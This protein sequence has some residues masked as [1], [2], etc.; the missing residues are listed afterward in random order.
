MELYTGPKFEAK[1]G[2]DIKK[3]D[4]AKRRKKAQE[5]YSKGYDRGEIAEIL[6]I[7]R[8]TV[9]GYLRDK[10]IPVQKREN[11]NNSLCDYCGK[12]DNLTLYRHSYLCRECLCEDN[13]PVTVENNLNQMNALIDDIYEDRI[14]HKN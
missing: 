7:L 10:K 3:A 1:T 11:K 14:V 8:N 4:A 13:I 12:L 6:G 9:S 2:N 5:L